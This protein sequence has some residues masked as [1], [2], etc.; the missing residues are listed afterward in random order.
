MVALGAIPI[1]AACLLVGS[2]PLDGKNLRNSSLVLICNL[3]DSIVLAALAKDSNHRSRRYA[4]LLA[5]VSISSCDITYG[6]MT[7][8]IF[9]R[10]LAATWFL[11]QGT[12]NPNM[13]IET[14]VCKIISLKATGHTTGVYFPCHS[15]GIARRFATLF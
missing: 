13:D 9:F 11:P 7:S 15:R 10:L 3:D 2:K 4:G 1:R 5:T 12:S 14:C 8:K 6:A